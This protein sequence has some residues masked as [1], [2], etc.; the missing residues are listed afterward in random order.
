VSAYVDLGG[1]GVGTYQ[2]TVHT[3]IAHDAGVT[4]VEPSMVQI[5]ITRGQ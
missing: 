3:E 4:R 5:T 1:L 2:L